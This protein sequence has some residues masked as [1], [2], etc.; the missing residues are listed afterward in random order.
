MFSEIFLFFQ[1][2]IFFKTAERWRMEREEEKKHN[3]EKLKRRRRRKERKVRAKEERRG[4][5]QTKEHRKKYIARKRRYENNGMSQSDLHKVNSN[6]STNFANHEEE[7]LY[8]ES[9]ISPRSTSVTSDK[10]RNT[11]ITR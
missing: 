8:S 4:K 1:V 3:N 10:F 2:R 9:R 11:Q 5:F 7:F 6:H